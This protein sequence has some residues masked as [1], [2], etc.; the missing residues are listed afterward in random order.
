MT[1]EDWKKMNA[2]KKEKIMF[3]EWQGKVYQEIH[4]KPD[5]ITWILLPEEEH[6]LSLKCCMN[7]LVEDLYQK[8]MFG[9]FFFA[10]KWERTHVIVT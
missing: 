10:N 7:F 3:K 2:G 9:D 6:G 5:N 4:V 1:S 8:E